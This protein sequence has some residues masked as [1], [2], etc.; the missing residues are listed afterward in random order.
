MKEKFNQH[1]YIWQ[2]ELIFGISF[3]KVEKVYAASDLLILLLRMNYI[4]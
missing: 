4:G 3:V 1:I 2:R